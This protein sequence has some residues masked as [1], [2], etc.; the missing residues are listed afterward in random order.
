MISPPKHPL[1]H[2]FLITMLD[3]KKENWSFNGYE[4]WNEIIYSTGP[5]AYGR[6][7]TEFFGYKYSQNYFPVR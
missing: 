5:W 1:L 2:K 7:F 3:I 4:S 6:A